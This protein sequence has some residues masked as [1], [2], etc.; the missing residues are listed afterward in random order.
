MSSS[1]RIH[2]NFATS[3]L[4]NQHSETHRGTPRLKFTPR[5]FFLW[6]VECLIDRHGSAT[7]DTQ[8]QIRDAVVFRILRL[9]G[10]ASSLWS[11]FQ[12]VNLSL[13]FCHLIVNIEIHHQTKYSDDLGFGWSL[14]SVVG[15][16]SR[17]FEVCAPCKNPL[18]PNTQSVSFDQL[19]QS[20]TMRTHACCLLF[21]AK[22][23]FVVENKITYI[24]QPF[25]IYRMNTWTFLFFFRRFFCHLR[26]EM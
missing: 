6:I 25:F 22:C 14:L 8:M 11:C 7:T 19:I 10:W 5:I 12:F 24:V 23:K 9:L 26:I 18:H 20:A 15:L 3:L 4:L 1:N 16:P 13:A 21:F 2:H 17:S